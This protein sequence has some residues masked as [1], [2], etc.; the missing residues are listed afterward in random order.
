LTEEVEEKTVEKRNRK[1]L[2]IGDVVEV[3]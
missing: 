1:K 3:H 2:T